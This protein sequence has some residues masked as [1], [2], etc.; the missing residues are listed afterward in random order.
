MSPAT[1]PIYI[2]SVKN[3]MIYG[4]IREISNFY[5]IKKLYQTLKFSV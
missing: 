4:K 3:K 2:I 5:K 1:K